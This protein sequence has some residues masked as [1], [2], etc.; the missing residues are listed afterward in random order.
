MIK[1]GFPRGIIIS[2]QYDKSIS[3]CNGCMYTMQY[4][5]WLIVLYFMVNDSG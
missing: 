3:H 2:V 4:G 1:F 5:P